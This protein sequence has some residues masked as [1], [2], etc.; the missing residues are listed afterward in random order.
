MTT[1]STT[2]DALHAKYGPNGDLVAAFLDAV[3]LRSLDWRQVLHDARTPER[4]SAF[5]AV[6]AVPWP[7]ARLAAVDKAGQDVFLSLGLSREEF[8]DPLDLGDLRATISAATKAVTVCNRAGADA[9]TTL[10]RPFANQGVEAA[11]EAI[12]RASQG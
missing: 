2:S 6:A 9:V 5:K 1:V 4:R 12:T 8:P 7:A 10:L 3:A 11:H